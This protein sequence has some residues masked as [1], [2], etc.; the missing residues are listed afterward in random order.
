MAAYIE[1]TIKSGRNTS[2]WSCE[3]HIGKPW[4]KEDL[5]VDYDKE[6]QILIQADGHEKEFFESTFPNLPICKLRV[7]QYNGWI[8]EF[9]ATNMMGYKPK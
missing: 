5:V 6:L 4:P 9:I 1:C 8:S 7:V 3:W 2:K